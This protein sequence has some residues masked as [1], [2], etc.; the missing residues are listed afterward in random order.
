[1]RRKLLLLTLLL[2]MTSGAWAVDYDLYI[3]GTQI[4]DENRYDIRPNSWYFPD[5]K[6][7]RIQFDPTAKKLTLTDVTF[8]TYYDGLTLGT[9]VDTLFIIG[10]CQVKSDVGAAIKVTSDVVFSNGRNERFSLSLTAAHGYGLYVDSEDATVVTFDQYFNLDANAYY[11]GLYSYSGK[12]VLVIDG[13]TVKAY[14]DVESVSNFQDIQFQHDT[15]LLFPLDSQMSGGSVVDA[16]GDPVGAKYVEFVLPIS[17]S[18]TTF[19]NWNFRK[20]VLSQDYGADYSLTAEERRCITQIDVPYLGISSLEGIQ[21][22]PALTTLLCSCNQLTALDLSANSELK[23]LNCGSN[24]LETLDVSNNQ[25]LETLICDNNRLTALDVSNN[26]SHLRMVDCSNNQMTALNVADNYDLATLNCSYNQLESL[27]LRYTLKRLDCSNNKLTSLNVPQDMD[28]L[29]CKY[30]GMTTLNLP[31][32]KKLKL[33]NCSYNQLTALDVTKC[34]VLEAL[35][36]DNNQLAALDV[37]QNPALKSLICNDNSEL[38]SLDVTRNPALGGL[39][40]GYTSL[41]SLNV[42]ENPL[43]RVL[44]CEC[45]SLS[46]L[47]VTQNPVLRTLNCYG[48]RLTTLDVRHNPEL[49]ELNCGSN[50][51]TALDV[52]QNAALEILNCKWNQLTALDVTQNAALVILDCCFNQLTALDLS[53]CPILTQLNCSNNCIDEW[54]ME[55][56]VTSLPDHGGV[57]F[58]IDIGPYSDESEKN[59]ISSE[60]VAA[61]NQKG[62]AVLARNGYDDEEYAGSQPTAIPIISANFPDVNFRRWLLA[63]DYGADGKLTVGERKRIISI[64]VRNKGITS[65][66]GIECFPKLMNLDCGSDLFE[67]NVN[68]LTSLDLSHF[69]ELMTLNCESNNLS[70]LDV[71]N[72]PELE[73]LNCCGNYSLENLDVTKNLQLSRLDCSQTSLTS[74][75]VTKNTALHYLNCADTGLHDLDLSKNTQLSVLDFDFNEIEYI[76]LSANTQLSELNCYK[77]KLENLSLSANTQL[78]K[79]NC[80]FNS[81][82][83]L[84]LSKNTQLVDLNCSSNL[85]TELNLSKCPYLGSLVCYDNCIDE[86]KMYD[87]VS[88]LRKKPN[89]SYDVY[90]LIVMDLT[91]DSNEQNVISSDEVAIAKKK[92][93]KVLAW[94]GMGYED[95]PGSLPTVIKEKVMA[96][97]RREDVIYD[98]NGRRVNRNAAN[99]STRHGLYIQNGRKIVK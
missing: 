34:S 5:I 43:L 13:A 88:S 28:T 60:Q 77:N 91:E 68:Q 10:N 33:L 38:S 56:L 52:T 80:G 98:L 12:D 81:L 93:W 99:S 72:N 57:L 17:I 75:N 90:E 61:A 63:Q 87:L 44:R 74:L 58:A 6:A 94:I 11:N 62:W 79:L 19:P 15:G 51:L 53:Q 46:E 24:Q 65:L 32:C 2:V 40:C 47:G 86:W 25:K 54:N 8:D 37:T 67:S 9:D 45:C 82:L 97:D 78:V 7:G 66:D 69:P 55:D 59:V 64:N 50:R 36:C 30:N 84:D 31:R 14:G 83:N 85:L 35:Y 3:C 18:S 29:Y 21:Y 22:F 16:D 23:M 96:N 89:D 70:E 49:E 4:T 42:S 48:N 26:W 76:D 39:Y 71:T 20:W 92:G 27:D 41:S 73:E 95:Y 1:M